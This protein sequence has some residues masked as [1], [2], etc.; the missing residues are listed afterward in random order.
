MKAPNYRWS[1][2][3]ALYESLLPFIMKG[4]NKTWLLLPLLLLVEEQREERER[5]KSPDQGAVVTM[6]TASA[7]ASLKLGEGVGLLPPS[8]PPTFYC[9]LST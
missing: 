9:H 6:A 3:L 4:R 2:Q 7:P 1:T 8:V 5:E